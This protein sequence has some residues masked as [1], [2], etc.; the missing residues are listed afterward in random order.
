MSSLPAACRAFIDRLG[1]ERPIIQA[2]MAGVQD[3]ALAIAVSNAGGLGSL[4]AAMLD[5]DALRRELAAIRTG[6]A[7]PFNLNFFC[8][9]EP[10]PDAAQ[11]RAWKL[12]G[13]VHLFAG[14]M[15]S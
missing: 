1:I 13:R 4:P 9:A 8:H 3:S 12:Q 5:H 11:E 6:T 2:P 15:S 14:V 7:R 10:A